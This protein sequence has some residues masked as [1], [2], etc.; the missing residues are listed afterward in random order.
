MRYEKAIFLIC[1]GLLLVLF[2]LN[3]SGALSSIE[4]DRTISAG[5]VAD[6]NIDMGLDLSNFISEQKDFIEQHDVFVNVGNIANNSTTSISIEIL[7]DLT[8]IIQYHN[9]NLNWMT[10][11]EIGSQSAVF[12]GKGPNIYNTLENPNPASIIVTIPP[13]S[14]ID[15]KVKLSCDQKDFEPEL[16]YT[17]AVDYGLYKMNFSSSV[18]QSYYYIKK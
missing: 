15:V 10:T 7:L 4:F 3:A 5:L 18:I 6:E 11:I 17:F 9:K 2:S 14:S 8:R 12:I 1:L 16:A 13:N